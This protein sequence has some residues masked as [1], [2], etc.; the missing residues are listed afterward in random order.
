MARKLETRETLMARLAEL[1][2]QAAE[3][4]QL[5]LDLEVHREEVRMQNERLREAQHTL[6]I[7]RDRYADLYDFAPLGYVTFDAFGS[8]LELN[9]TAATL[10]G[11]QRAKLTGTPFILHVPQAFRQAFL[12]HVLRTKS[13]GEATTELEVL[14]ADGD[15]IP[16]EL[17]SHAVERHGAVELLTAITDLSERHRSRSERERLL[18]ER[19]RERAASDAKGRFLAILS[20]ELRTPLTPILATLS[21]WQ[22]EDK[23]PAALAPAVAM[24]RRNIELEARLIDDLLD[25]SRIEH[26]KLRLDMQPV[27]LHEVLG[28]VAA[29]ARTLPNAA[30]LR[31][32][33]DLRATRHQTMGDPA[34][35]QQVFGNLVSNAIQYTPAGGTV[36]ILSADDGEG[37]IAIKVIDTGQGIPPQ[38]AALLFEPFARSGDEPG[39]GHGGLGL[40]L[41]IAKGLVEAH[42]GSLAATSPGAGG[43]STFTVQMSARRRPGGVPTPAETPVVRPLEKGEHI[44]VLLVEDH[45]DSAEALAELLGLAGC[46]VT[47]ADSIAAALAAAGEQHRVLVSDLALPDGSGRELLGRLREQGRELEGI[48]LSG[49]G[50]DD[51]VRQSLEAGFREHLKKPVDGERLA[52]AVRRAARR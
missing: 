40:G 15:R 34:R 43:G 31:I 20:H 9:L 36:T 22:S 41:A 12:D 52:A 30:A 48:V 7:S 2:A 18:F 27:N 8:V 24:I 50:G 16:V 51:D 23:V 28:R 46:E 17:Y 11:S 14:R 6:E 37:K 35:L 38:R 4:E 42:G 5:L 25:M 49:F 21:A 44:A 26:G 10:L 45:A 39:A 47:I 33:L 3:R 29:N 1:E 19:E 13:A 32:D